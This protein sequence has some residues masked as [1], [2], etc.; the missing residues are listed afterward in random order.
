MSETNL[1]NQEAIDKL[2]ELAEKSSV[3]M[4]STSLDQ[5]PIPTRPMH[6]QEVDKEGRLWFMSNKESDK[7]MD[8]LKDAALQLVFINQSSSEYLSIYGK[9]E[10]YTDQDK[11]DDHWSIMA[12]AWFDGKKDPNI[13]II[14]VKPEEVKYWDTK[15]GKVV[16]LAKI[17]YSALTGDRSDAGISGKIVV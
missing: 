5:R 16:N 1:F 3:C 4:M 11:I 14:G 13:S 15:H 9:A 2:K 17:L 12:N 10:I 8:L 7:N 6:L